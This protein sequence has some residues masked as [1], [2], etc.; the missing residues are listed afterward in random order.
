MYVQFYVLTEVILAINTEF[1]RSRTE[2][3]ESWVICSKF[4]DSLE[5]QKINTINAHVAYIYLTSLK[6]T[7]PNEIKSEYVTHY[8][9]YSTNIYQAPIM[10]LESPGAIS[11]N[12]ID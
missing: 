6:I 1:I 9:I 10:C 7:L 4:S 3:P 5:Q 12:K 8:A 2:I 11:V